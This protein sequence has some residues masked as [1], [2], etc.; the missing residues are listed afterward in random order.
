M[1]LCA[2]E[3]EG[4]NVQQLVAVI[5]FLSPSPIIRGVLCLSVKDA[6]LRSPPT[7]PPRPSSVYFLLLHEALAAFRR[8]TNCDTQC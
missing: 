3:G 1:R 7:I 6:L 5:V 2:V 4:R 8:A